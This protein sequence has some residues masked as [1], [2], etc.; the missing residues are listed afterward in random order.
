MV[1]VGRRSLQGS[2]RRRWRRRG[3]AHRACTAHG[4]YAN[5]KGACPWLDDVHDQWEGQAGKVLLRGGGA[6]DKAGRMR[7]AVAE[8]LGG[9]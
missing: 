8:R 7:S 6:D 2:M 5:E 4:R 1:L 9:G 3:E